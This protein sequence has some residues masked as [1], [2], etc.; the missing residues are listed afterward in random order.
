MWQLL[1]KFCFL[2]KARRRSESCLS[3]L[4]RSATADLDLTNFWYQ[5]APG[6][7]YIHKLGSVDVAVK[8]QELLVADINLLWGF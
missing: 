5:G 4:A 6:N 7:Q 8:M 2:E 1:G 3:G